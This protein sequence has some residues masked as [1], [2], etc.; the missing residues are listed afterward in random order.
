[1]A[2]LQG[3]GFFTWKISKCD[4]GNPIAI[5]SAAKIAGLTHLVVKVA[6][7]VDDYNG[8]WDR[9]N[10]DMNT[11]LFQ[12]LRDQ[13]IQ[14]WGYH[15]IYG[16]NPV[17]EA[18]A[19]IRRIRK[20]NLDLFAIDAEG[21]F[22][23]PGMNGAA[24]Q[25]MSTLR[26]SI[27]TIPIAI[28]SYRYPSK[29]QDFPW[30]EFVSKCDIAMPQVYWKSNHNAGQQLT[31]TRQE[32]QKTAPGL[33]FF[34]VGAAFIEGGWQPTTGD[35][36]DFLTTAQNMNLGGIDFWEWSDARSTLMPGVWDVVRNFNW[37]AQDISQQ[38][39]AALN[40]HNPDQVTALYA[41]N[42]VHIYGGG[43]MVQGIPSIRQWYSDLFTNQLPNATFTINGA[44]GTGPT[45]HLLWLAVAPGGK[46]F[47]G[48]TTINTINNKIVYL[49]DVFNVVH[50]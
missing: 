27:N 22:D 50:A 11:A 43:A 28:C 41:A 49:T 17:G 45:R 15:F 12:A 21:E 46:V 31:W 9:N 23:K 26:A 39:F 14:V 18:N 25:Y 42:G 5:A 1:M 19:S 30:K 6:D 20:F 44:A 34:P 37:G 38:L 47:N 29:H 10:I 4:N 48:E 40:S 16:K 2:S 35:V 8:D 13:G 32:Y 3:K 36:Q 24:A 33:V 7:G